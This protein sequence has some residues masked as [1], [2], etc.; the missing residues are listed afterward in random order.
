M[1]AGRFEFYQ[2]M[3]QPMI[4]P[5]GELSLHGIRTDGPGRAAE[6]D[7][8]TIEA[9]A[10]AKEINDAA[11]EPIMGK[12]AVSNAKMKHF[13]YDTLRLPLQYTKNAEKRKVISTNVVSIK[14]LMEQFPGLDR[15]QAVGTKTLA[16]R[17]LGT[18]K[19]FVKDDH[20]DPDGRMR[21]QFVQD[22]VFARIKSRKN[23]RGTG[24]N[25]QNI[26]RKLRQYYLPD[27]ELSNG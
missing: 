15:L 1:A 8:V 26:D 7:R 2:R 5:L 14:R 12:V 3:S 11:G 22:T 27:E 9:A 25:L 19:G 6:F 17:R 23:P 20:V 4:E 18:I 21:A 16:H 24:R 13:L 10:L